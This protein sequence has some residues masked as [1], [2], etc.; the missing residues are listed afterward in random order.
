MVLMT[1]IKKSKDTISCNIYPE[2]STEAG[3]I[4][5]DYTGAVLDYV[6]PRGYEDCYNCI[7]HASVELANMLNGKSRIMREKL[8][9]WC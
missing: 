4:T 7:P 1:N 8:V 3:T 5:V 9:I 6:L 2:E